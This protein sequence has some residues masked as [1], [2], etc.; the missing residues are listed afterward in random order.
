MANTGRDSHSRAFPKRR[1]IIN[2]VD[3]DRIPYVLCLLSDNIKEYIY[4][5]D[6]ETAES[7]ISMA[8]KDC[9]NIYDLVVFDKRKTIR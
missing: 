4:D 3:V 2:I 8:L 9:H 1:V 6:I 7:E 5:V